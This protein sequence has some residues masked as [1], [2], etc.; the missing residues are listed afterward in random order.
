VPPHAALR[1]ALEALAR[2]Y[3]RAWLDSDPLRLPHGY[4]DPEDREVVAVVAA[5]L[6][7]GRVASILA[8]AKRALAALGPRPAVALAEEPAAVE[9]RLAGFRHRFTAG[10]DLAWLLR[11]VRRA[12]ERSGSLGAFLAERAVPGRALQAALAAWRDLAF[13]TSPPRSAR[14]RRARAFLLSDP[15]AGG[16]CKRLL[17]LAR[18]C[19]RPDDGVDLGLWRDPRLSPADLL[20]PLDVHVHRIA[21]QVGL[22]ERPRPDWRAAEEVTAALRHYDPLDPVRFDFALA[23]PGIVGRCRYRHVAE[24]CGACDLR[25]ACRVARQASTSRSRRSGAASRP[26][27]S[28]PPWS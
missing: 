25:P 10:S 5:A 8:S 12:R 14:A 15:R 3:D 28:P 18:W 20:V 19:V 24:V 16:A 27:P 26:R 4:A 23:R 6:A 17:L 7:Y 13:Q 9:R 1:P 11:S 2:R 22:T 21:V